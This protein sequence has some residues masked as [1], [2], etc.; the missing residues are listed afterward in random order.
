MSTGG[1]KEW[2]PRRSDRLVY[3]VNWLD[4]DGLHEYLVE[5]TEETAAKLKAKFAELQADVVRRE[6]AGHDPRADDGDDEEAGPEGF[7]HEAARQVELQPAGTGL[8]LSVELAHD[9]ASTRPVIRRRSS[10]TLTSNAAAVP[11]GTG[12]G[13][14]QCSHIGGASIS[15]W[16]PRLMT[17]SSLVPLIS[18]V[19]RTQRVHITQ[20][21]TNS[22]TVSPRLRRRLLNGLISA[23]R[24]FWPYS[25]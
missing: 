6:A 25:K 8:N 5:M 10:R 12:S 16:A 13:M 20:R 22:V 19:K 1:P 15:S 18:R 21:S 23:R 11:A 3:E 7:G 17:I 4:E 24:S 14:D 9:A 2:T